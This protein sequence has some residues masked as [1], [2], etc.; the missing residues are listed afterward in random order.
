LFLDLDGTVAD[1]LPALR[2]VYEQFLEEHACTGSVAEFTALNGP[3]VP[4]IV[5]YL[6]D[7]YSLAGSVPVLLKRYEQLVWDAYKN[8][9][10]MPGAHELMSAAESQGWTAAIV[11]S[12]GSAIAR[13]WLEVAELKK[14]VMAVVGQEMVSQAKP[15]PDLYLHALALSGCAAE[16][17]IAVEDSAAGAQ[18]ALGAGIRTYLVGKQP[19]APAG[20]SLTHVEDLNVLARWFA[21]GTIDLQDCCV[22]W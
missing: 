13:Q 11:T 7:R 9:P 1:S 6:K 12:N 18:S 4:E 2:Q 14:H 21:D 5:A 8:V 16:R 19:E 17:S 20:R 22:T 10:A 3:S 15:A